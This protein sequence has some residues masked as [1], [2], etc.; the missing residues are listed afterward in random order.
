MAWSD[1]QGLLIR[2]L[3]ELLAGEPYENMEPKDLV[4]KFARDPMNANLF[5]HASMAHNNQFFFNGLSVAPLSLDKAP[6]VKDSLEDTF[7]SIETLRTTMLDTADAMFGPGFVWLVWMKNP[8]GGAAYGKGGWRI[9]TTYIA[10]TPYPEAGY[11]QQGLDMATNNAN[12]YDAY[13]AQ[14]ALPRQT[15]N[16]VGKFGPHS[17]SGKESAKYP[18]GGTQLTPALCVNT[19]EHAYMYDYGLAGKRR[20]LADWWDSIDWHQVEMNAPSDAKKANLQFQY[21]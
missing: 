1:Y 20:Y 9:L 7:G 11:R 3:N 8:E 6:T 12:S 2:K 15:A 13:R 16:S 10:G 4:I 19:W 17:S 14:Q 18:P 5:N 21:R